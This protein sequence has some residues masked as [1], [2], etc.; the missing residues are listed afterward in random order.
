MIRVFPLKPNLLLKGVVLVGVPL[1]FSCAFI[2]S[3]NDIL[4]GTQE[5]LERQLKAKQV[6]SQAE[7]LLL[8]FTEAGMSVGLYSVSRDEKFRKRYMYW[9]PRVRHDL[10]N[11]RAL[12][13]NNSGKAATLNQ[14][15]NLVNNGLTELDRGTENA[16]DNRVDAGISMGTMSLRRLVRIRDVMRSLLDTLTEEEKLIE[17]G[18]SAARESAKTRLDHLVKGGMAANWAIA[19]ILLIFVVGGI[20]ERLKVMT[21]NTLRI[22]RNLPL[23]PLVS[24]KDEI[25]QLDKVFHR[26]AAS[27]EEAARKERAVIDYAADVICSIDATGAFS[28]VSPA[29][30][31]TWGYDP[32]ELRG[33]RLIDI[34]EPGDVPFT[35]SVMEEVRK[36]SGTVT[37]DNRTR[38]AD[39]STVSILWSVYWSKAEK[40][41]FCVAHDVTERKIAEQ[42]LKAS[43]QRV[44]SI[45]ES[46]LVGLLVINS[47][48]EVKIANPSAVNMF[49]FDWDELEGRQC[50]TLLGDSKYLKTEAEIKELW[51]TTLDRTLGSLKEM[52]ALK[53]N[54]EEFPVQMSLIDFQSSEGKSYLM[55]ILD[56]SDLREVERLRREF[57]ATVTHELR[58]PLTSIYASMTLLMI[59]PAQSENNKKM[60]N[61]AE[62]SCARLIKL[63]NDLLDVEKFDTGMVILETAEIDMGIIVNRSIDAVITVAENAGVK[64]EQ[65]LESMVVFADED[66]IVQVLVNLLSNAVKFSPQNS[67]VKIKVTKIGD[68]AETSVIDQG[69]GISER[70]KSTLFQR[71]QQVEA[72]DAKVK[73]GSGLGLAISRSIIE[74]H[75]GSIGVDTEEGKGSR[76]WF[77]LPV[78]TSSGSV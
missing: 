23:N 37:F 17:A 43:E 13:A 29:S 68:Y 16:S 54:G 45:L 57:V 51:N 31:S 19:W 62:R 11:L 18:G 4:K 34:V 33:R 5:E 69:R 14:V 20:T 78:S 66:R 28:A 1:L 30:K 55:N 24:G 63:I 35:L 75:K 36:Q 52:N 49:G 61:I 44:R 53:K 71:F 73:G 60:L 72:A 39:G 76:F 15:T 74:Q 46:T 25:A 21:D 32:D 59:D 10:S 6:L 27:L 56:V 7:N 47:E 41:M 64:I 77:R 65:E 38:K 70:V 3:L 9:V 58:T 12:C 8:D 50:V 2:L 48:G 67:T 26:M 42:A 40:S 22:Q